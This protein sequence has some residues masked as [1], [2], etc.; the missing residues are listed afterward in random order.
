MIWPNSQL[1]GETLIII[2]TLFTQLKN[3]KMDLIHWNFKCCCW[4]CPLWCTWWSI[5][6]HPT[7][8]CYFKALIEFWIEEWEDHHLFQCH[9]VLLQPSNT[10]KSHLQHNT[11]IVTN[12]NKTPHSSECKPVLLEG[13]KTRGDS[14]EKDCIPLPW[15]KNASMPILV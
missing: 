13:I 2:H 5:K 3:E 14:N 10:L 15:L 4:R 8:R 12:N 1:A 9:D 11:I 6:Q 7:R